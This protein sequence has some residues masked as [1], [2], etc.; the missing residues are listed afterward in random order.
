ML[1]PSEAILVLRANSAAP[2]WRRV[3]TQRDIDEPKLTL[4]HQASLAALRP[5]VLTLL[6]AA[7]P[8]E[9]ES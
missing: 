9:D 8:S 5:L 4:S 7:S 6:A 2:F 3:L 1:L